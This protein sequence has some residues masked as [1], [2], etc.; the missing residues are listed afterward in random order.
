VPTVRQDRV[1]PLAQSVQSGAYAPSNQQIAQ[2]LVRDFRS[3]NVAAQ[4]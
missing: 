3:T 1:A 2:A 4:A